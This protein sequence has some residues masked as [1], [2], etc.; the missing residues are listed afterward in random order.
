MPPGEKG[1][2]QCGHVDRTAVDAANVALKYRRE[3]MIRSWSMTLATV[4]CLFLIVPEALGQRSGQSVTVR[5]GTVTAM[6]SVDLN[7]GN[8]IGGALVGGAFGAALT[9][10]SKGSSRRDRNA[11]IGAVL[12][13]VE[14][15]RDVSEIESLRR[16]LEE[17]HV[18]QD[19]ASKWTDAELEAVLARIPSKERR[20]AWLRV[21]RKP[22]TEEERAE[23][24]E[25]IGDVIYYK[26]LRAS[27]D[28]REMMRR[29]IR[30]RFGGASY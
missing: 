7:D 11:A 2:I 10:S 16:A 19:I 27:K 15:M 28:G 29:G 14:I 13:G 18:F 20:E 23:V 22:Y 17:R 9:R 4:A 21:A 24:A 25:K 5:T 26:A 1:L 8:A 12:G 3:K 6:R 30:T